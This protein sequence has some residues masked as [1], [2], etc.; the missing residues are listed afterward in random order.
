[1]KGV[2]FMC[3]INC[4]DV[5]LYVSVVC[6]NL[7]YICCSVVEGAYVANP[8]LVPL[9]LMDGLCVHTFV[10]GLRRRK[11]VKETNRRVEEY[12]SAL[13][14]QQHFLT[15][16]QALDTLLTHQKSRLPYLEA[17]IDRELFTE[18]EG[19]K[20]RD[21]ISFV[22]NFLDLQNSEDHVKIQLNHGSI[23]SF[24]ATYQTPNQAAQALETEKL[25]L[26]S[27]I[28]EKYCGAMWHYKVEG[29][30]TST[31]YAWL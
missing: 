18:L 19:R 22:G 30:N 11:R 23:L 8:L 27:G 20:G 17:D 3:R 28:A 5:L 21:L 7:I 29:T 2:S 6:F 9:A 16:G 15:G 14:H 12:V 24:Q 25:A 10:E 26:L 1:M 31:L 13:E 4:E